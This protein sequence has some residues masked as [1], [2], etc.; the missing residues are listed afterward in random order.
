MGLASLAFISI[1]GV[2]IVPHYI[3]ARDKMEQ[4]LDKIPAKDIHYYRADEDLENPSRNCSIPIQ[5][6][7]ESRSVLSEFA[8]LGMKTLMKRILKTFV[9]TIMNTNNESINDN[10]IQCV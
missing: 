3:G 10:F 7:D 4:I 5:T 8:T 9:T 1:F 2:Q 6:G